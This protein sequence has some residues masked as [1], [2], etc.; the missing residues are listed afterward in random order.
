MDS[1]NAATASP[2]RRNEYL[3][4]TL[5]LDHDP[6]AFASTELELP[7][8][9]DDPPFLTY[10]VDLP[11]ENSSLSLLENLK[12]PGH[13]V[14]YGMSGSGKTML[15]YALEA[16][17][18]G[19]ADRILVVSQ[20]M[21]KGGPKTAV[22]PLSPTAFAEAFATD[23]FVQTLEQFDSLL[24]PPDA[25][26]TAELSHFWH[27]HIPNFH[28]NLE[29]HLSQ[30]KPADAPTGI[31]VWWRTWKRIVV[32]YTP[33]NT[34]RVQFL[35]AVLAAGEDEEMAVTHNS[36]IQQ[37]CHL[38][39]RL[40]YKQIFYLIDV[41]DTPQLNTTKL[42]EQL[43]AIPNWLS[44]VNDEIPISLKLF[45]PERMKE[46]IQD[47]PDPC[48]PALISPSFS[49]IIRWNRPELLQALI[50]NRFRSA[51]SW[52]RGIEV[53]A[54]QEIAAELPNQLI[55]AANQSPR[56]LLQIV[57]QLFRVHAER[58]ASD[59]TITVDDWQTAS[60][61]RTGVSPVS[62]NSPTNI[63][64]Q[65]GSHMPTDVP[66]RAI[67]NIRKEF[68]E[69]LY[70]ERRQDMEKAEEWVTSRKRVLTVTSPPAQGKSWFLASLYQTFES[71]GRLIF[72]VNIVEFLQSGLLGARQIDEEALLRW[73]RQ[74]SAEMRQ[75]CSSMPFIDEVAAPASNLNKLAAHASRRCWPDKPIYLCID[76]GDE[77][78]P[79]SF[80]VIKKEI[81]EPIM[82]DNNSWRLIMTVRREERVNSALFNPTET[83][84]ELTPLSRLVSSHPGHEQL[85]KLIANEPKTLL[86]RE[87]IITL[88]PDYPWTHFGLNTFLYEEAKASHQQA[89]TAVLG[90]QLL[91][92][93]IRTLTTL[94]DDVQLDTLV[95]LL[96]TIDKQIVLA[97]WS[98]EDVA[99]E[100]KIPLAD[101]W[102]DKIKPLSDHLLVTNVSNHFKIT[103][104]L[105]EFVRATVPLG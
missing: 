48:P 69:N 4:Q 3:F 89:G 52:I 60:Q 85:D 36:A 83:R 96:K 92:R 100:L 94:E 70:V 53:L 39:H 47:S 104:G 97:E 30:G 103:D 45:L 59:P 84:L 26:L 58:D 41:A 102:K 49:A 66:P 20:P 46:S 79:A 35:T 51:G 10:F 15:R 72:F 105:R 11:V 55:K 12:Q 75:R 9:R 34:A 56:R 43:C 19:L 1:Q 18:R 5:G 68:A 13:A 21:G 77:P 29:R 101:V 32:R 76:G 42:V 64:L 95:G 74:F 22:P 14:V 37:G 61:T 27:T 73:Q 7:V 98:R 78:D 57:N 91:T 28:R 23:L 82:V 99:A 86:N 24:N 16:Q 31:S 6:F 8:N 50:A 88:L 81:L 54:S 71:A 40:G 90:P 17:C 65:R 38:A 44:L 33:L 63:T 2:N 25:E 80:K 93:A 87:Q 67:H 62:S